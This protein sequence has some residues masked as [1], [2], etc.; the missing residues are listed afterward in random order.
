ML[1]KIKE[2][3]VERDSQI[4]PPQLLDSGDRPPSRWVSYWAARL[5]TL[6]SLPHIR[7]SSS[8]SSS[9]KFPPRPSL[10]SVSSVS[11]T[12]STCLSISL[13]VCVFLSLSVCLCPSHCVS[14]PVS[15]SVTLPLPVSIC[16]S[17][18]LS[19]SLPPSVCLSV[20][21][22]GSLS[23]VCTHVSLPTCYGSSVLR[24]QVSSQ[25]AH[26][27]RLN[28]PAASFSVPHPKFSVCP[29]QR[30][31]PRP[32]QLQHPDSVTPAVPPPAGTLDQQRAP[33]GRQPV[34][35]SSA[36]NRKLFPLLSIC[37]NSQYS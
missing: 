1:L 18:Y 14:V 12:L 35:S 27:G 5:P 34:T 36:T 16:V 32:E 33:S 15:T 6:P 11:V 3:R 29:G 4:P 37:G 24:A 17:L 23:G 10:L 7:P 21:P 8:L 31:V 19:L 9:G 30:V 20:S 26:R 28:P 13:C 22:K 2:G 25:P